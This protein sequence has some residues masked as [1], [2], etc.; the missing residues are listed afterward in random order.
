MKPKYLLSIDQG[1]TGTTVSVFN[2]KGQLK[3][4]HNQDY[5][6]IFPQPGWVEHDPKDIW[7]STLNCLKK[8]MAAGS[9]KPGEIIAIGITN[10]RETV[11]A[12]DK[13]TGQPVGNAIVWQCRRTT[14]ACERMKQ[15]GYEKKIKSVTGLVLDPYFSATKMQWFLQNN[16]EAKSLARK[17]QLCFGT[18][19]S[20]LLWKLSGG[21]IFATDVSNASRT[22]LMDLATLDYSADMLKLFDIRR[23]M[24]PQIRPSATH[25]GQ[26]AKVGP[27]PAGIPI[28]GV[29][30]DQQSALF[31]QKCF[32]LGEAKITFGT[33]SFVLMNTKN[34]RIISEH[35]LLTTVAWQIHEGQ[36][37]DYALEG[38]AFICGAAVQWIRDNLGFIKNSKEIE[39]LAGQVTDCGGVQFVPAFAGLGAPFWDPKVRGSFLGLTRGTTRQHMARA[40]LE[41]MALQN[42]DVVNTMVRDS[43]IGLRK[44]RVDGGAA[45]NNL[46]MQMQANVLGVEVHRPKMIEST[47]LG[48]ALM[49]GI[50]MGVWPDLEDI[51][52]IDQL[53]REFRS[54]WT[55]RDRDLRVKEWHRALQALRAYHNTP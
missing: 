6:Q 16:F 3:V 22:L 24:L 20:F 32:S 53:D 23:E 25:Y 41:A 47:S 4:N 54:E 49:A 17:G 46:L 50:G 11:V 55:V 30:G 37:A 34:R 35:G 48:A 14:D 40:T 26:T 51:K 28:T 2:T 29:I 19:D 52:K 12:W 1:T 27:L 36:N 39:K 13:E 18:I 42:Y 31:G 5:K 7:N 38:G 9:I 8:V 45:S 44:V 33:G 10:Q 15:K 21:R 43:R